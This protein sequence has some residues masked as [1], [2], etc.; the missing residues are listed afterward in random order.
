MAIYTKYLQA[1]GENLPLMDKAASVIAFP[2]VF[3]L[4][5]LIHHTSILLSISDVN[6]DIEGAIKAQYIL[7]SYNLK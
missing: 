4:K 6:P 3:F 1:H 5:E 7:K 2:M